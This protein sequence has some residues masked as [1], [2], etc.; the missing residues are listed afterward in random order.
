MKPHVAHERE[1]SEG[2]PRRMYGPTSSGFCPDLFSR[3]AR[4]LPTSRRQP[5][6]SVGLSREHR[7][8]D[9]ALAQPVPHQND[10]S[11]PPPLLHR[12]VCRGG[13]GSNDDG[14]GGW[15]IVVSRVE[16]RSRGREVESIAAN[17]CLT[18]RPIPY[19]S[20]SSTTCS[21]VRS[22][23]AVMAPFG[24]DRRGM[25]E[26][27]AAAAA[28]PRLAAAARERMLAVIELPCDTAL[29]ASVGIYAGRRT[30]SRSWR[31]QFE[32]K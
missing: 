5:M 11:R 32:R 15:W 16:G 31:R 22:S 18:D 29:P 9:V 2:R 13:G 4:L 14:S 10:T 27:A 1:V 3:L 21:S 23:C 7:R 8:V 6:Q 12:V 26:R 28:R 19:R 20:N 30:I 24:T 17:A 25:L